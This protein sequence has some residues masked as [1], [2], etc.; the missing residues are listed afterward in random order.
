MGLL[1]RE[2]KELADKVGSPHRRVI[3]GVEGTELT[4]VGRQAPESVD[5]AL[6][7]HQEVVEVVSNPARQVTDGFQALRLLEGGLSQLPSMDL[8]V[9]V[10]GPPEGIEAD[11]EQDH[12]GRNPEGDQAAHGRPQLPPDVGCLYADLSIERVTRNLAVADPPFDSIDL[13]DRLEPSAFRTLLN[14]L[15]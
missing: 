7:H 12:G 10:A 13:R 9:E 5:V 11:Q 15:H 4:I 1:A 8:G 3:D 14:G 2:G 6:H